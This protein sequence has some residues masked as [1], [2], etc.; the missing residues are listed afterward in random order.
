MGQSKY[1]RAT[2][3]VQYCL[4]LLDWRSVFGE[5]IQVLPNP[6]NFRAISQ[7]YEFWLKGI[8]HVHLLYERHL[9]IT[10]SLVNTDGLDRAE[11]FA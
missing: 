10:L 1:L 2:S 7:P 9:S 3:Y 6:A 5:E 11:H 4:G 8:R